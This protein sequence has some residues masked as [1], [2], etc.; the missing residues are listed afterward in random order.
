MKTTVDLSD[1]VLAE[2]KKIAAETRRSL[3]EVM[4]ETIRAELA[5]RRTHDSRSSKELITFR[6][7]GTRP[8]VNLDS[9]AD[10]LD[11]MDGR[12]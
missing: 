6:G 9:T 3:K 8:G 12:P 2:L 7:N 11:L 10:M 1:E 4:E 5:R